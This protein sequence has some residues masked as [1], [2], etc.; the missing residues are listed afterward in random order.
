MKQDNVS[1]FILNF[2]TNLKV[3]VVTGHSLNLGYKILIKHK[4]K[5]RKHTCLRTG[6]LA[7]MV[8]R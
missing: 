3:Y 6:Q 1:L 5:R 4:K 2:S 8:Q 7:P